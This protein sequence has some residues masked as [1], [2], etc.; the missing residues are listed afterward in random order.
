MLKNSKTNK[1]KPF[2]QITI[3]GIGLIGGS[4]GRD[5]FAKKLAKAVVGFDL[6]TATLNYAKKNKI[7]SAKATSLKSAVMDADL[8]ILAA[9]VRTIKKHIKEIAPWVKQTTL[10]ID[11]GSTKTGINTTAK[12]YFPKGNFVGCHP[13]AGSENS[14]ITASLAGLFANAPCIIVPAQNSKKYFIK[15]A[16]LLWPT[17]GARTVLMDQ[18]NHDKS[19]AACSHLPHILSFALMQSAVNTVSLR[20]LKLIA[21]NSFKSYTRIAGSDAKMWTDIFLDNQQNTLKQ[22]QAFAKEL[23]TLT[24]AIKSSNESLLFNYIAQV[25]KIRRKM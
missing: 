22:I 13:M 24:K 6:N 17:L 20:Q 4:L 18:N 5:F 19:L 11:V 8:I 16:Q 7:I 23:S 1:I 21:G 3:I 15:Q 25:A 12:K 14:G 2:N 10:V 9:P